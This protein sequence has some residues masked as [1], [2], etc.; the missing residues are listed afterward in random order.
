MNKDMEIIVNNHKYNLLFTFNYNNKCYAVYADE[1]KETSA[2]IY[3]LNNGEY[4]FFP[5]ETEEEWNYVDKMIDE[6]NIK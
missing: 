4:E 6:R 2:S 3:T 1:N 5:I